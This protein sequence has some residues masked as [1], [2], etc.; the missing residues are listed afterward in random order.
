MPEAAQPGNCRSGIRMG[1]Y[2]VVADNC[3]GHG[4]S[5][6]EGGSGSKLR[7]CIL[8]GAEGT[9]ELQ[10]G[11]GTQG[12]GGLPVVGSAVCLQSSREERL[13][14]GK[15]AQGRSPDA[16]KPQRE[17]E[18]PPECEH[19]YLFPLASLGNVSNLGSLTQHRAAGPWVKEG[20]S[21]WGVKDR[22]VQIFLIPPA[23]LCTRSPVPPSMV[24]ETSGALNRADSSAW[25]GP[26]SFPLLLPVP[27][28]TLIGTQAEQPAVVA[29]R[30]Q[31][32][33]L[34][35]PG[36]WLGLAFLI[37]QPPDKAPR[38]RGF[39]IPT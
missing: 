15:A 33:L 2:R 32:L 12:E 37:S 26:V 24:F 25:R 20:Y 18:R 3:R 6:K 16:E 8:E 11:G 4:R 13:R 23:P 36:V 21:G 27:L 22:R 35:Q 19:W 34:G 7:V 31:M 28:G 30:K 38:D 14:R 1:T 10:Q 17:E 9:G 29:R 5:R 39:T